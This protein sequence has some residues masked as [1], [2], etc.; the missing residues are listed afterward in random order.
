VSSHRALVHPLDGDAAKAAGR[1][2]ALTGSSD[3]IDASVVQVARRV[4]GIV[5]TGDPGELRKLDPR[6]RLA[7]I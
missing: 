4:D 6:V 3:V 1:L 7:A 5:V 2:C